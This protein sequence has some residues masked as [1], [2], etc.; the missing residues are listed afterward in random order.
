[1]SSYGQE[2][3]SYQEKLVLYNKSGIAGGIGTGLTIASATAILG[4]VIDNNSGDHLKS[5]LS[6]TIG[7]FGLAYSIYCLRIKEK[8]KKELDGELA[9]MLKP[10]DHTL[11]EKI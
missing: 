2:E 3:M 7:I 5:Y 11:E 10:K 8:T 4:D 6:L 1:M 9:L